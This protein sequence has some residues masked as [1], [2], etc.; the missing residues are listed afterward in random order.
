M[1]QR[2]L[3]AL[4]RALSSRANILIFDEATANIDTQTEIMI[5]K[6]LAY[7]MQKKTTILIA[8]RLS[9]IRDVD[10]IVVIH[11]GRIV[12][13][14]DHNELLARPGLYRRMYELQSQ[15]REDYLTDSSM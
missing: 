8:H 10:T 2:Q 14:G 4:A 12:D 5:Q 11:K 3:I 1:G 7:V 13:Q 15:F 6:A 9:T